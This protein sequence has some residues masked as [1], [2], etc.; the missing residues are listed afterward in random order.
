MQYLIVIFL[1]FCYGF[2]DAQLPS[3]GANKGAYTT[4][5]NGEKKLLKGNLS[6]GERT[7]DRAAKRYEENG[8]IDGYIASK[9]MEAISLLHQN[10]PKEA[11]YAF[12]RAED[13]YDQQDTPNKATEA[14]LKLCI[15]KYHLYYNE[16]EEA[17][18]YLRQANTV[19]KENPNSVSPVFEIE[20]Q[21]N[22]GILSEKQGEKEKAL[23][24]YKE[25]LAIA[26]QFSDDEV[27][28]TWEDEV[29]DKV[30]LLHDDLAMPDE[31]MNFYLTKLDEEGDGLDLSERTKLKYKAGR[32]S[33]KFTDYDKAYD[34][35]MGALE[36][37][38]SVED[39]AKTKSMLASIAISVRD[40]V[41]ALNKNGDAL[42]LQI[43]NGADETDIFD[44]FLQQG[45]ICQKLEGEGNSTFWYKKTLSDLPQGW[46]VEQELDKFDLDGIIHRK[47]AA[48]NN[49]FNVALLNFKR[50]E[51]YLM[52]MGPEDQIR[53]TIELLMAKG[54]LY[55]DAQ[56]YDDAQKFYIEAYQIIN[57]NFDR[58]THLLSETARYLAQINS[59]FGSYDLAGQYIDIALNAALKENIK[60]G[61]N[62]LPKQYSDIQFHYDLLHALVVKSSI[63]FMMNRSEGDESLIAR[64]LNYT[65]FGNEI[66]S[67]L[68]RV[69]RHE[70]AKYELS[71]LTQDINH[72]SLQIAYFLF[73]RFN[74]RDKLNDLFNAME[75][76]KSSLL[77]Q[78]VQKLRAQRIANVPDY[79]IEKENTLK[80]KIA[81]LTSEIYY[82]TQQGIRADKDRKRRLTDKL[83]KLES[84]YISYLEF[85]EKTY[86][87][88]FNLKYN[89][90]YAKMAE[91]QQR[92][93]K[94]EVLVNYVVMDTSIHILAVTSEDIH[95][96][97]SKTP[98]R[99][100]AN[101]SRYV[102]SL[103]GD[104]IEFYIT[105]SN[106]LY[107][108]LIQPIE[109]IIL[110][111]NLIIIPDAQLNYIPF[112]IIPTELIAVTTEPNDFSIFKKIPYLLRRSTVVYNYS[113]T[114]FL[115]SK[116][117][118]VE[119]T[120]KGFVGYAPDFSGVD[121]FTLSHKHQKKKYDDLL[122]TP[123]ENAAIEVR[124]IGGLMGGK[125]WLGYNAT[126]KAFKFDADTFGI[127]HF[128][129]HGILNNKFPLYS[130]LVLLGDDDE[131]GLLHTYE[132]YNMNISAELVALS[133][134]NTGVGRFQKG[135]GSMSIARGFAYAGCPNIAMTLWPV[136][137]Q[138]TQ[139]LME[140]F[141]TNLMKGM[142]KAESLQQAKLYFIEKGNGSITL[143]YFWSGLLIS[144]TPDAL[145]SIEFQSEKNFTILFVSFFILLL[146]VL[147]WIY[148]RYRK[149]SN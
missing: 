103:K 44:S 119:K 10:K 34:Q 8:N 134:C 72:Q 50:A 17:D 56:Y 11:F 108:S 128:A 114:L 136:S 80:T 68:S 83:N 4:F 6:S 62:S 107:V 38:L 55:Y 142:S 9:A 61:S 100:G 53:S 81:F 69:H 31:S 149:H 118:V 139:I 74:D 111:K 66:I 65:D 132:L 99:L 57:D 97:I 30:D 79:V 85:I 18:Q 1:L 76:S 137:D 20:L 42:R 77:L 109:S 78:A 116:N 113:S 135:E 33:F 25:I 7:F 127:V 70:S 91:L 5:S 15:G 13:L 140:Q 123:L 101:I 43:E 124:S 22:L 35:L 131:D 52:S 125:T 40:Y 23:A 73:D 122:L 93:K 37:D 67:R 92:L 71:E 21:E 59:V 126:E 89:Q 29:E 64:A 120:S 16:N 47:D 58:R 141:Y 115:E 82:E 75:R 60:L 14:Y 129:T 28:A 32:S 145:R 143:P 49:Q 117:K 87:K 2:S 88:Y 24:Y 104:D 45:K 19:F 148:S 110:D 130:N 3:S 41:D 144:G 48:F 121:S 95:Y 12:K 105:F 106:A 63:H 86:Q 90:V 146:I 94:D 102:K 27:S 112:E 26:D 46:S 96:K 54:N 84:D 147:V 36:G 98:A 51:V 39:K 138:A 133:A